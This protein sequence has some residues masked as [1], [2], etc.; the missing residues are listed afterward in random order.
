MKKSF[1]AMIL[2][3]LMLVPTS[4]AFADVTVDRVVGEDDPTPDEVVVFD[5]NVD[6]EAGGRVNGDV[7]VVNGNATIAGTVRG[8]LV[9]FNGDVEL[10]ETAVI[11]GECVIVNGNLTGTDQNCTVLTDLPI[12]SSLANNIPNIP[13]IRPPTEIPSFNSGGFWSSVAGAIGR[14]LLFGLIA[15]GIG[16][17]APQHVQRVQD[18]MQ[19]NIVASGTVGFLTTLAGM[20]LLMLSGILILVCIG[21]PLTFAVTVLLVAG[22]LFGWV[23]VGNSVGHWLISKL[24]IQIDNQAIVIALGTMLMTFVFGLL[25]A[26]PYVFG[27]GLLAFVVICVGLGAV[28]LTKFGTRPFPAVATSVV[29]S[30]KITAVLETLPDEN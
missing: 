6:I 25:G 7:V 17:A 21:I 1:I 16:S 23:T 30:D 29:D 10:A 22:L 5:D 15:F 12:L 14:T 2:L 20:S 13:S 24:N 3:L 19:N 28:A 9:V 8:S 11:R 18:T 4:I 27:E 26:I